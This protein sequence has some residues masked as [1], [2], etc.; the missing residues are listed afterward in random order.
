MAKK[1]TLFS[2]RLM[3][4]NFISIIINLLLSMWSNTIYQWIITA[5]VTFLLWLFVWMDAINIGQKDTQ[6]DKIA[7]RKMAEEGQAAEGKVEPVYLKWFG[8]AGGILAQAPALILLIIACFLDRQTVLYNVFLPALRAWYFS[9]SQILVSF[10]GALP[11]LLFLFPVLFA[12]VAGLGYLN[13]PAQQKKM[14]TIIERNKA[15]KAKRVQ[16]DAKN[17]KKGQR[18]PAYRR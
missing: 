12:V 9:Y 3:L 8:F 4:L 15:K 2:L 17:K 1:L 18:K 14:E 11:Y 13:G 10:E 16:D 5:L 7:K 6:K